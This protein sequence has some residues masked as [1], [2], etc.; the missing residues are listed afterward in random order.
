MVG[1]STGQCICTDEQLCIIDQLLPVIA[2]QFS[3]NPVINYFT[4]INLAMI[5]FLSFLQLPGSLNSMLG[6]S[7]GIAVY[8]L[9]H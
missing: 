5:F 3:K 1:M 7:S 2:S 6:V 8:W 4:C 9:H